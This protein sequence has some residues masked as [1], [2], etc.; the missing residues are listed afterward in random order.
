MK[1]VLMLTYAVALSMDAFAVAITK[2]LCLDRVSPKRGVIVGAWFGGFQALMPFL[3]YFL[4]VAFS[5]FADRFMPW[6]SFALLTLIGINMIREACSPEEEA[7]DT[8]TRSLAFFPMF[9]MA[10]ATSIDAFGVGIT[11]ADEFSGLTEVLVAVC[12]IGVVTFGLSYAGL[13][14]GHRFGQKHKKLA[15]LAGGVILILLGVKNL[16]E[17]FI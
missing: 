14:I 4:G 9:V 13:Y 10:V 15:E 1:I 6:I 7:C 16:L 5:R 8:D 3:G 17:L 2:G 11:F 12:L